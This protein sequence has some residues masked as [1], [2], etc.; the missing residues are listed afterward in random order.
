MP[1][2]KKVGIFLFFILSI[3]I[4]SAFRT[5]LLEKIQ[6]GRHLSDQGFVVYQYYKKDDTV[7]AL[8]TNDEERILGVA[9]Q[10]QDGYGSVTIDTE[11]STPFDYIDI[12]NGKN[13]YLALRLNHHAQQVAKL[14]IEGELWS[15]EHM[16]NDASNGGNRDFFF[17][18][19]YNS[20]EDALTIQTLDQHDQIMTSI[21]L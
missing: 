20:L 21:S 11:P 16:L 4:V 3:A 17:L 14:Q 15:E 7:F 19:M 5:S 13:H 9:E 6:L 1:N 8:F 10:N 12:Q 18:D 2:R